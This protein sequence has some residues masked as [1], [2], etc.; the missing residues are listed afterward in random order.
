MEIEKYDP[1]IHRALRKRM[2]RQNLAA[3]KGEGIWD[4]VADWS[5]TVNTETSTWS[6]RSA[7][8]AREVGSVMQYFHVIYGPNNWH[9]GPDICG[10][11]NEPDTGYTGVDIFTNTTDTA[12]NMLNNG[13][14]VLIAPPN[15]CIVRP[16]M[17]NPLEP[18]P[19]ISWL[20][21]ETGF[22][23]ISYEFA[24]P[25]IDENG[26]LPTIDENGNSTRARDGRQ[27]Y[28][29]KISKGR[30]T[31]FANGFLPPETPYGFGTGLITL[32]KISLEKG[33]RIN[34]NVDGLNTP[35]RDH[36]EVTATVTVAIL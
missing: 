25:R 2:F 31:N 32:G 10:W 30:L 36:T 19:Q 4:L 14:I 6:Y 13:Q 27:W 3:F 5:D 35:F 17:T 18:V 20:C 8:V 1:E 7:S 11:E 34:W 24:N 33:D 12:Q 29:D 16:Q 22:Y 15:T 26:I 9:P 28:V 23:N 21:P